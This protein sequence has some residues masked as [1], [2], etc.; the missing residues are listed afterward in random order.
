MTP[1]VHLHIGEPKTGT[2]FIQALLFHNQAA[3]RANGV[4]V[5]GNKLDQIRG[6]H[7]V[8]GRAKT[9]GTHDTSGAWQRLAAEIQAF[10]GPHAVISMEMLT[11]ARPPQ[12]RRAV[13]AFGPDADVRVVITARDVGSVAPARWQESVQFRRS[14][15]FQDYLDGVFSESPKQSPSGRH[16]W[17]LHN[18]PL[19]VEKWGAVVGLDHVT[20]VTVPPP[21]APRD[22]LWQRFGEAVGIA[23]DAYEPAAAVN[24]SLGAA[25]AELM[26]RVNQS[27][28]EQDLRDA[29]YAKICRSFLAKSVLP[30]LKGS[31]D[32]IGLPAEYVDAATKASDHLVAALR[33]SGVRVVGDL[34]ELASSAA[35]DP[36]GPRTVDETSV[37][38]A[39]LAAIVALVEQ[40][41]KLA[42]QVGRLRPAE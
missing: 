30:P 23:V 32:R 16:F 33:E 9:A 34:D 11:R 36:S 6:G 42:R 2:T 3:L 14:W 25:S 18:T 21:S 4:L 38:T 10:D 8:L 5:A 15:T 29:D 35:A 31:E 26:R 22:L 19:T 7:D 17:D 28:A 13:E 24:A 27:L 12:V 20:V 1:V 40:N 41:A 39:A 37:N